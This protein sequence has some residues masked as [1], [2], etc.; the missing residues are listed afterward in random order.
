[1]GHLFFVAML[2]CAAAS[3][4][5]PWVGVLYGYLFV[6]LQPQAIWWWDFT[7]S[8]ATFWVIVPTC[9]GVIF[10][11]L[12]KTI[13][14]DSLKNRRN[15]FILVLWIFVIQSYFFGAYIHTISPWRFTIPAVT[16]S[17]LNKIFFF[18]FIACLCIDTEKK[19]KYLFVVMLVS[20]AYLIYWAN[21]QYLAGHWM[22]RLHGPSLLTGGGVYYDQN[23][24]AMAFVVA[25]P[26]IWYFGA[27]CKSKVTRIV[28]WVALAL[29]WNAI[30][31]TGSRG[32]F[33]GLVVTI[34]LIILRSKRRMLG[35]ALIPLF[36]IVF[37]REAG[38][39]MVSRVM[40]LDHYQVHASAEERL[41]A[42][43]AARRMIIAH[44]ITGVGLGSFGPAFPYYSRHH[45]REAH[46]T[47]YQIAAESGLVAGI[48]YALT[49]L[50]LISSL[51]KNGRELKNLAPTEESNTL[52]MVNEATMIGFTGLAVCSIFLSLQQFEIFY[53]LNVLANSVL[54]IKKK[55][56]K[57]YPTNHVVHDLTIC[58]S[59]L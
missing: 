51:W 57:M 37:M 5:Y 14:I 59:K 52:L 58:E 49:V 36:L 47:F 26:F 34:F 15:L 31:L 7:D 3:L 43:Q 6:V 12:R 25:Q 24:F 42:W 8:R 10:G 50:S 40:S 32:G 20:F 56:E 53:C 17:R 41:H 46:D 1:M 45:P 13:K 23:D 9:L 29:S 16:L 54:Y 28:S 39:I 18:Y 22:G 2:V 21:E 27:N 48:M 38:P 55:Q 19:A 33:L 4:I 11:I 44:P 35:F 30:F